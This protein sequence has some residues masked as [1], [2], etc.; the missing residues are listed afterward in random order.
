MPDLPRGA[1]WP[2]FQGA[3]M[4]F[5][6]Q[7]HL[8]ELM[9]GFIRELPDRGW[10]YFFLGSVDVW[11]DNSHQI[12]YHVGEMGNL[13]GSIRPRT[14]RSFRILWLEISFLLKHPLSGDSHCPQSS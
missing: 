13:S 12:M 6:M 7:I 2:E 3:P 10:L 11:L 8:V 5:L 4:N 1:C 14:S 9:S